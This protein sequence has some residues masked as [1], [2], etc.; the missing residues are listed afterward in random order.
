MSHH[1]RFHGR[2]RGT[3]QTRR[4]STATHIHIHTFARSS[5]E[6]GSE[7][8]DGSKTV[9][10]KR[11]ESGSFIDIDVQSCNTMDTGKRNKKKKTHSK[12][13][14][15]EGRIDALVLSVFSFYSHFIS[16]SFG[17]LYV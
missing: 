6:V 7:S 8:G 4:S 2:G 5:L 1:R 16:Q 9:R 13:T 10:L 14:R 3:I 17:Y 15:G 12:R 11:K